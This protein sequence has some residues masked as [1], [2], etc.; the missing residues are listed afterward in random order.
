M[1]KITYSP[2]VSDIKGNLGNVG[3]YQQNGQAVARVRSRRASKSGIK[4]LPQQDRMKE[5]N[6]NWNL[7]SSAGRKE[8]ELFAKDNKLVGLNGLSYKTGARQWFFSVA[9]NRLLFDQ[10]IT[11]L[12]PKVE[13]FPELT[14]IRLLGT[15]SQLYI[16]FNP[17]LASQ[18][19][20]VSCYMSFL[21][22]NLKKFDFGQ[23]RLIANVSANITN[24][25]GVAGFENP[26]GDYFGRE[27][28]TTN[29]GQITYLMCY[30][31]F[32]SVDGFIGG[33]VY[34]TRAKVTW[35]GPYNVFSNIPID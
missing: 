11:T 19:V 31:R 26:W 17:S 21:Q 10:A 14:E 2:I 22:P 25:I 35:L 23:C 3:F 1:A 15:P 27:L 5:I 32:V 30:V 12:V 34:A 28:M 33:P 6:K 7:L 20:R 18:F 29:F 8:W 16:Y 4:Q 13:P 24:F 9:S